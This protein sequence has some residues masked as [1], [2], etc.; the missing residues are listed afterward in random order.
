M[1]TFTPPAGTYPDTQFVRLATTTPNAAIWLSTNGRDP[2]PA[3]QYRGTPIEVRS[4]TLIRAKAVAPPYT[5]V[6]VA[7]TGMRVTD[8]ISRVM[9][10]EAEATSVASVTASHW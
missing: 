5:T 10:G 1:P 8:A 7:I 3:F 6:F 2:V 9:A 4:S